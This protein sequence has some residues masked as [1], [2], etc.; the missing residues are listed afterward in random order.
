MTRT[1]LK[2]IIW[3]VR[4]SLFIVLI[5]M[6]WILKALIYVLLLV[7]TAAGSLWAGVPYTINILATE[8]QVRAIKAGFPPKWERFLYYSFS[9]IAFLTIVAGWMI[10]TFTAVFIMRSL[11][12]H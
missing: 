10:L 8:W 3:I 7:A 9:I 4:R 2:I 12:R 6:P 11:F 5:S 1:I